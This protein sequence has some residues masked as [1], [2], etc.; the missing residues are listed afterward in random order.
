ML[1]RVITIFN[2]FLLRNAIKSCKYALTTVFIRVYSYISSV[3][4]IVVVVLQSL[5]TTLY[6]LAQC[7]KVIYLPDDNRINC[8]NV[9]LHSLLQIKLRMI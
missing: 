9:Y 4:C 8:Y 2:I 7:L 5:Y 1:Y 3:C 6:V